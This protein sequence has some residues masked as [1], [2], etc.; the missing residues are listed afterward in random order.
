MIS[1][2]IKSEN[3]DEAMFFNSIIETGLL[4]IDNARKEKFRDMKINITC[5]WEDLRKD[6]YDKKNSSSYERFV[7]Y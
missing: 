1:G 4:N 6:S 2:N 5:V 3:Y 7:D